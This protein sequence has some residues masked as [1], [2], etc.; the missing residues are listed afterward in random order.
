MAEEIA[1]AN[2]SIFN[3]HELLMTVTVD[4]VILYTGVQHSS[5]STYTVK[6]YLNQINFLWTD[7]RT[8]GQTNI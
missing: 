4:W 2:E 8:D 3:F 6:F 7:G 1:F 5:T